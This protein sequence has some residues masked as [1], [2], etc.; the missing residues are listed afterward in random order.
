[1]ILSL[2]LFF[3]MNDIKDIVTSLNNNN[4]TKDDLSYIK[5]IIDSFIF[6]KN[7]LQLKIKIDNQLSTIIIGTILSN[8]Y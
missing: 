8:R 1:M 4:L 7:K 3:F 5:N 2:P 6:H